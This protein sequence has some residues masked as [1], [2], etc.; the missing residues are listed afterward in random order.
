MVIVSRWLA[1]IC[2]FYVKIREESF[3]LDEDQPEKDTALPGTAARI[4]GVVEEPWHWHFRA[5][6]RAMDFWPV[7]KQA[8]NMGTLD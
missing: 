1:V 2:F 3:V 8:R 7:Q 6:A 5:R 4:R